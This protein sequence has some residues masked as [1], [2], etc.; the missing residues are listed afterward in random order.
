[1]NEDEEKKKV[2]FLLFYDWEPLF[3]MLSREDRG[4]LIS[5]LFAYEK[6]EEL[7]KPSELSPQ[8]LSLFDYLSKILD[9][10]KRQWQIKSNAGTIGGKKSGES[11]RS[12][13][14]ANAKQ[15][16]AERSK[17]EADLK[18]NEANAKQ[19]E[20]KDKEKDK[21]KEDKERVSK[22]T[23]KK[24]DFSLNDVPK[25]LNSFEILRSHPEIKEIIYDYY[26]MRQKIKK[27]LSTENAVRLTVEKAIKLGD[28]DPDKIRQ[29][30]ENSVI[31][32]WQGI[33][34]IKEET[35]PTPPTRPITS[36]KSNAE[37]FDELYKEAAI[38]DGQNN[39]SNT[40]AFFP[41][42]PGAVQ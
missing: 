3:E 7:P 21:E 23:P 31:N 22:D 42:V 14:E 2:S 34:A 6:R 5:A 13:A 8:A 19:N 1:M 32:S 16:E 11:R 40:P 35:A 27:P 4:D 33:F 18:Q 20:P 25:I 29:I 28:G 24:S 15:N 9:E 38:Y 12:K 39:G 10:N 37:L 41:N 26:K 30:F 36:K 17:R